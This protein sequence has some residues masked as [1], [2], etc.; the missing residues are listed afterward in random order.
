ML[1]AEQ[2]PGLDVQGG[3]A[4]VRTFGQK[5]PYLGNVL[6]A[7][8]SGLVIGA[9]S[10]AAGRVYSALDDFMEFHRGGACLASF[11]AEA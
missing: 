6:G 5:Q 3:G 10:G 1:Q 2:A 8:F 11:H 4:R 9:A 7:Q